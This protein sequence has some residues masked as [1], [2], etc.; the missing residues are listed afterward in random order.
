MLLTLYNNR[1]LSLK[2]E[3]RLITYNFLFGFKS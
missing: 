1:I 3:E 2:R